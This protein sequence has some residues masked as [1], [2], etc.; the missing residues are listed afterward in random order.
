M[1]AHPAP[2]AKPLE[3][4]ELKELPPEPPL[5]TEEELTDEEA[6]YLAQE[7]SF[8]DMRARYQ[9]WPRRKL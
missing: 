1:K 7:E 5:S 2:L 3:R 6:F 9:A 4:Q 8:A